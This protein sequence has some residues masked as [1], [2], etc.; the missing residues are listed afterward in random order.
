MIAISASNEEADISGRIA[1]LREIGLTIRALATSATTSVT[2]RAAGHDPAPYDRALA[3]LIVNQGS[4]ALVSIQGNALCI[5]A[6]PERLEELAS[7]FFFAEDAR[8]GQHFH[9]EPM[10]GDP[11]YSADSL[12]LVVSVH[13][14]GA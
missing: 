14:S 2:F 11:D 13:H 7:C 9:F 1:D 4:G 6:A 3:E 10:P 12:A 8:Q 5:S